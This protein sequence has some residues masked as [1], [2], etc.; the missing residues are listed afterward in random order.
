MEELE[1]RTFEMIL[2]VA[3]RYRRPCVAC[4]FGK[5]SIV[6]L[7]MAR[8][9]LGEVP[10]VFHRWPMA[11]HKY[12]YAQRVIELW[13]LEVH[14]YPPAEVTVQ[15]R[16]GIFEIVAYYESAGGKVNYL[17][18]NIEHADAVCGLERLYGRPTARVATPW[19]LCFVGNKDGDPDAYLGKFRLHADVAP[20]T[21]ATSLCF[22][23]RHW[24]D[25]QVW[26]YIEEH[27]LPVHHERYEKRPDGVWQQRAD[28][29]HN[30]DT[31]EACTRCMRVGEGPGATVWCPK[32]EAEVPVI[33]EQLRHAPRLNVSYATTTE[34]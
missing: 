29:S 25:A 23:L 19:D 20:Q 32:L 2:R 5:D 31:L 18:T 13:N 24:S 8:M 30:P 17:P 21:E 9:V 10:V 14:D 12:A 6:L 1:Q 15:E 7:H 28:T 22:P 4:S 26:A 27:G 11:P 16:Q 34:H 33:A 3:R